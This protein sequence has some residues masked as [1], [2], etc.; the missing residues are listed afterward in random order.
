MTELAQYVLPWLNL[1]LIPG[2]GYV[3]RLEKRIITLEVQIQLMLKNALVRCGQV[4]E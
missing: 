1:L 3:I 4:G 2:V